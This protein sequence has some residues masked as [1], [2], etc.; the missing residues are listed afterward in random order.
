MNVEIRDARFLDV[1]GGGMRVEEL[2]GGFEF[3]EGAVWNHVDECLVFSDMP[4]DVMRTWSAEGGVRV[5]RQPSNMANGNTYDRQGRLIT[6]EHAASRVTR[7]EH[8]GSLTVLASHYDGKELNSP[9]DVVITSSGA[10]YFSDPTF[11]RMAYYGVLREPQL[12][13]RGVYR[14]DPETRELALLVDDFDQPNG[15]TFSLDERRLFVNDTMRAHVR[16]FDVDADGSLGNGRVWAE[17]TGERGG[18][19]DGMKIDSGGNLYTAGPGGVQVFAPDATCL[20][21]IHV[22]QGVANFTWGGAD[23]RSL[24]VT[25]GSS[26][27]RTRVEV[28][29]RKLF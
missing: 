10:I 29:G 16:V 12:D 27:Y 14:L 11:G 4:G 20:G 24:F 13:V 18:L 2:A 26:L 3:T 28:P 25:A 1:V 8:D 7:T 23:L 17:L 5:F 21:V 9:N 22:P 6:C 15:L 19:A